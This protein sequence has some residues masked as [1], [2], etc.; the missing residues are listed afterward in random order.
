MLSLGAFG[1]MYKIL[2]R[3]G[4]NWVGTGPVL[5]SVPGDFSQVREFASQQRWSC[6]SSEDGLDNRGGIT[7][8]QRGS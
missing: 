5:G 4:S 7:P 1:F 3:T 2:M 6:P 8:V